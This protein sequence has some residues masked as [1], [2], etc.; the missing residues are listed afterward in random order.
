MR[1]EFIWAAGCEKG[2]QFGGSD[3]PDIAVRLERQ[4]VSAFID[5]KRVFFYNIVSV[6]VTGLAADTVFSQYIFSV[7]CKI[8][9][10]FL[11]SERIPVAARYIRSIIAFYFYV[12]DSS[13]VLYYPLP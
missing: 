13:A 1:H 3:L 10:C 6:D 5:E 2:V 7:A 9:A 12:F 11:Y 8:R 4:V